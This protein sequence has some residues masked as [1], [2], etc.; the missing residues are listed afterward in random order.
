M[1]ASA[2]LDGHARVGAWMAIDVHLKND[3]PPLASIVRPGGG[4]TTVL[5]RMGAAVAAAGA[6]TSAMTRTTAAP[7]RA[8]RE[9]I[10]SLRDRC[11][12]TRTP[13]LSSGGDGRSKDA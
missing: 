3:G 1:E 2:L 6:P 12:D 9:A 10:D 13:E 11:T 8:R 7:T 4:V 5:A